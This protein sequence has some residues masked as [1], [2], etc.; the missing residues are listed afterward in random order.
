MSKKPAKKENLKQRA[1]LNSVTSVLDYGA[2]VITGFVVTPFLVSGLGSTLFGVWKVLGQF[3]NYTSIAD[4][5]ATEVLKW[6]V[7]KDRDSVDEKELR[8]YVTATFIL[9]M[10]ILPV[11]LIAGSIITWFSPTI[12]G[13]GE[14]YVDLVRITTAV[15][16]LSLIIH[17]LFD[18][19]ESI[20]RGMNLGFKRM[21]FRAVV[22]V[23]GGGLQ[24]AVVLLG[25]GLIA[26]ASI[27]VLVNLVIG[28]TIYL[29]VKKHVPWF[30]FGKASLKKSI[31]FIKTSGWFMGWSGV[32]MILLNSDKVLLGFLTGPILVTQYVITEYLIKAVQGTIN[33]VVH[34]VLPGMGKLYG[35]GNYEKMD[36]A[37]N[38]IMLLTWLLAVIVGSI[39]IVFNESFI[40][41]WVGDDIYAGQLVNIMILLVGIQY[42][43]I[44][45]D[46][47]LIN[48]SL[49]IK[50]K[51]FLGLAAAIVSI[52]LIV[53][54]IDDFGIAGLCA[55]LIIGRG[56]LTIGY[57]Y[58]INQKINK[59][60]SIIPIRC[61]FATIMIWGSTL[62]I[63]DSI[64]IT[65]WIELIILV[66]IFC[67]ILIPVTFFLGIG[68]NNR[69]A[70][71]AYKQRIKFFNK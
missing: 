65:N 47:T 61:V 63:S 9:V 12:T 55:G 48:L 60:F 25:Y 36:E 35:E 62:L 5:K 67:A 14:E 42:L 38:Q 49:D 71:Y 17:K 57:P 32:K 45:N 50:Q 11:I 2:R 31:S 34:G 21:G 46:S 6:A 54:L 7:A 51:V 3:T 41:V 40:Q 1:Y 68:K 4:I 44:N 23:I 33:N 30:G 59:K 13:V 8:E 27:Q 19:F 52:I 15:L 18:L 20:L 26:L 24:I 58:I 70:I 66:I 43:F 22:F 28:I 39:V 29:I 10:M 16:V 56:I 69:N 37:R 53:L 64:F